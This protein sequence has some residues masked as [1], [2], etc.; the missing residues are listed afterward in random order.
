M[1]FSDGSLRDLDD[2]LV[3]K[4]D[5]FL[6]QNPNH[7][8]LKLHRQPVDEHG[9]ALKRPLNRINVIYDLLVMGGQDFDSRHSP[10]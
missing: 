10:Y 7:F 1:D 8:D 5:N 6:H 4:H 2:Y 3:L 9:E